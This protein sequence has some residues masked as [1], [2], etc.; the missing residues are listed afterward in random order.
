MNIKRNKSSKF[1][2]YN[3]LK[4]EENHLGLGFY[5]NRK[6]FIKDSVEF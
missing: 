3:Q 5:L 1:K 6:N 4:I 2:V